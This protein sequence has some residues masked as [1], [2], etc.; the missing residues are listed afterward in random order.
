VEA[1]DGERVVTWADGGRFERQTDRFE[2]HVRPGV[3]V[4]GVAR[5][6]APQ[7]SSVAVVIKAEGAEVAAVRIPAAEAREIELGV[8]ASRSRA[9]TRIE[10][11][12]RGGASFGSLH[13]WFE[14]PSR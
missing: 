4:R 7:G 8:P 9:R 2:A 13:Y 14:V 6:V 10:V 12:T 1:G 5:L 3:A 11:E